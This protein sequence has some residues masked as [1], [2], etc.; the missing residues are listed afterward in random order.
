MA[1]VEA[2]SDNNKKLI[3]TYF[4]GRAWGGGVCFYE[5]SLASDYSST[6]ALTVAVGTID[7][8][9]QTLCRTD[10]QAM[11]LFKGPSCF[12]DVSNGVAK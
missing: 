5:D 8:R 4:M 1:C 10:R 12:D 6:A 9:K 7:D 11:L 3:S 2:L